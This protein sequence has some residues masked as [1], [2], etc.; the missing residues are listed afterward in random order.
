MDGQFWMTPAS[1]PAPMP[2]SR[3]DKK[4]ATQGDEK[5]DTPYWVDE[6]SALPPYTHEE[7]GLDV[8][9]MEARIRREMEARIRREMEETIRREME[10][11]ARKEMEEKM[12]A[13]EA[14]RAL[15]AAKTER[16]A[17]VMEEH[18]KNTQHY[19]SQ[20]SFCEY[21]SSITT[22]L[23]SRRVLYKE[24]G[25]SHSTYPV[26][27]VGGGFKESSFVFVTEEYI[28]LYYYIVSNHNGISQSEIH[29]LYHF[30]RTLTLR[31]LKILDH[32]VDG[33]ACGKTRSSLTGY[34]VEGWMRWGVPT[35]DSHRQK[36]AETSYSTLFCASV[37]HTP[38]RTPV[39]SG[40]L[41]TFDS[42]LRLIPGSYRNGPWRPLDGLLGMYYNEETAE[43]H[44]GPPVMV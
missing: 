7:P 29:P 38:Q 14:E 16:H 9:E 18:S 13:Q 23:T 17:K 32:L 22:F 15:E 40:L 10:T 43:L 6:N 12:K 41:T 35:G 28:G 4:N 20:P 11:K 1:M 31:D 37:T 42:V 26:D 36:L 34:H 25:S 24:K 21:F 19:R 2:A 30:D 44:V 8:A 39:P 27:T 3:S 5:H 33:S